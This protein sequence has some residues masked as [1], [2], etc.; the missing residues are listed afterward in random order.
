MAKAKRKDPASEEAESRINKALAE[1]AA[2]LDLSG[3]KLEALPDS[4][5][6]LTQLQTLYLSGNGLTSLPESFGGLA[7]LQTLSLR[8]NGLT[9]LPESFGGLAGLQT[10][11]LRGNG[12]TSLPESF[13]G[14]AGLRALHLTGNGL[15]SLPESFGGLAGL[16][17]LHLNGNGLTSLPESFGGLAGLRA[18]SLTGNGLTSLPESFGGLAGLQALSLTGN[19]LTSLPESFGGLAG[20]QTLDLNG[21]GLTSLPESFGGL[22]GLQTL[23]LNGNGLTSLPESFGGLAGLQTLYLNGNGLTSLPESFGGLAGLETLDLN[24]N[25]LTSLPE[26]FGGLAGLQTLYLNGNGLT[27]LP[28]SFGGLAGL[29]TLDLNGNGLTSLPESFGGLAGLQTLDLN[30]NGLT[31]LPESF[32]GLA[33]LQ[34]LDL[35]GNGLTSLPESFGGLAGLETLHLTGNGLTSLPESF[36]GLAGLQTL[37]LNGNGLTSLPESFGGLAGLETLDLNGNGLTSLPESL[38]L[39][40]LARLFLHDNGVLEIPADILGPTWK[41]CI[42]EAQK[43]AD[44]SKILGY[45]FRIRAG[46]SPLNEV[47]L[48]LLGRGGVGK[49]SLVNRFVH[50]KFDP[51]SA[52]TEGIQIT[53]WKVQVDGEDVRVH[54]WD[55]G[56]QEIM[57]ATHQFFLTERTLYLVVLS[58]REGSEDTDAEY[59]LK[60]VESFGGESPV[61]VVLNKIKKHPFDVNGRALKQKYPDIREFLRADCGDEGIGLKDLEEILIAELSRWKSWKVFFPKS[62]FA[63]KER[64]AG[65]KENYL[66]FEEYRKI[67]RDH[68]EADEPSQEE[69]ASHLHKLGIALN[70]TDDPRLRDMNIL[71]PHWV[72]EGIYRLLNAGLLEEKQGVLRVDDLPSILPVDKYP[73][74]MHQFVLDLMRKFDLCFPFHEET[75]RYLVPELLS[76]QQPPEADEFSAED[77]LGFEYHYPILPE[78]LLPRFIVRTHPMSEGQPRWRS[79]VILRFEGCRALVKADVIEKTVRV[80]I[81]GPLN[82]RRRL[83]AV[84]RS[85]FDRIHGSIRDLKPEEWV[86]VPGR[87]GLQVPY[88]DLAAWETE[89]ERTFKVV[90]KGKVITLDVAELLNGVDLAG[91]WRRREG[92]TGMENLVRVFYSYSHKDE[93]LRN[94]LETHLK[95]LERQGL[96]APWHDRLIGPGTEWANEIDANLERADLILLLVSADFVASDYCY[97]KEMTRALERHDAGEARV[98]PIIIRDTNWSKAPFARLQALPKDA[99]PVVLWPDK[100]SAWT[101]VSKGIEDATGAIRKR[102]MR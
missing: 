41:Q 70:Y 49:T 10:L 57:H 38:R 5:F 43:P 62:W 97:D 79:G 8:G 60:L 9:S 16:E 26:S 92:T 28:E 48:I 20:L 2:E 100:D 95:I 1:N 17:T 54:V 52:K 94:E 45:Y 71:N 44:P 32:G 77:C 76:K 3:L 42:L 55:F 101:N 78:G 6:Q 47:K 21:N 61:F 87:A 63:I 35:N 51:D 83:L 37:D 27:S 65:M 4:L 96:I 99:K 91:A 56:G 13:G 93:T 64:L 19:G 69:L 98:I 36:G 50:K 22:A 58:G 88:L 75:S 53:P 68:A 34:T 39:L 46:K 7:G 15:T 24:G 40:K 59:W 84:I 18:L 73:R 25:G 90:H 72:T 102:R 29:E 66:P 33:G 89:R 31:S 86:S 30:G 11:S 80:L 67:C 23:D 74:S 14:L 81:S 12:L 82:S 85:D